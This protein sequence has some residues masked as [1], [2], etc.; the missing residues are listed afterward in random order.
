MVFGS[1][2]Q[3]TAA[4]ECRFLASVLGRSALL[5]I[6]AMERRVNASFRWRRR[7]RPRD[8]LFSLHGKAIETSIFT[9]FRS[10][11][12][13]PVK[14]MRNVKERVANAT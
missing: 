8:F 6:G 12:E 9:W 1:I 10:A 3:E 14:P 2:N 4:H 7:L 11:L 5:L 13:N